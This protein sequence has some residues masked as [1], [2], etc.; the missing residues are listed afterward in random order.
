MLRDNVFVHGD[1]FFCLFLVFFCIIFVKSVEIWN[2]YMWIL[3]L[4]LVASGKNYNIFQIYTV[5]I[6]FIFFKWIYNKQINMWK[7]LSIILMLVL[8]GRPDRL[9]QCWQTMKECSLIYLCKSLSGWFMLPDSLAELHTVCAFRYLFSFLYVQKILFKLKW[10]S[11]LSGMINIQT[12]CK[13]KWARSIETR[14]GKTTRWIWI[15][16]R[17]CLRTLLQ[18]Q[19]LLINMINFKTN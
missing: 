17:R 13:V 19:T 6:N 11:L 7:A 10:K 5:F 15:I 16:H 9:L 1:C 4:N 14:G 18:M 8:W 12:V 2:F 3:P